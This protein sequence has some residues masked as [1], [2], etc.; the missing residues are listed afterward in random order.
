MNPYWEDNIA[1]IENIDIPMYVVAGYSSSI[2]S[3]G[4]IQGFR[5]AK[6]KKWLRVHCTQEWFDIYRPYMTDE[7]QAFFDRYLKGIENDWEKTNPKPIEHFPMDSYPHA[8]TE[9]KKLYLTEGQLSLYYP[10]TTG[11]ASYQSET[12]SETA[13]FFFTFTNTTTLM[14]F[15]KA[16]LWV[17]CDDADDMDIYV[18]LRKVDKSGK[19]LEH[20]NIPWTAMPKSHNY[21]EDV[22]G[23][24]IIKFTGSHGM[25]RVS[26]RA[27]DRSKQNSIMPHHPHKEVQ[28]VPPGE[29][30][31]IEIGLWPIGMQFYEAESLLFRVGGS[32]DAYL[33]MPDMQTPSVYGINKG[34]HHVDCHL[35]S[36]IEFLRPS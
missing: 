2:H 12:K 8:K 10:E 5:T 15:T 35:S 19:V 17:S 31:P 3:Y 29:I 14:G 24:N 23:S 7:L 36:V 33:E 9:Y 30:V 16:K 22:V 11:A 28:K 18:S 32:K 25:L 27:T 26:H 13:D 20:V 1:K 6:G 34:N 4:T 21:Q